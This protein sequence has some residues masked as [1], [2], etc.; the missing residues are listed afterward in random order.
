ML[1]HY[2]HAKNQSKSPCQDCGIFHH[3]WRRCLYFYGDDRKGLLTLADGDANRWVQAGTVTTIWVQKQH[4]TENGMAINTKSL[5]LAISAWAIALI[6]PLAIKPARA[7]STIAITEIRWW[8]EFPADQWQSIRFTVPDQDTTQAAGGGQRRY[9]IQI[10]TLFALTDFLC[11]H[12]PPAQWQHRA[13][14]S[15]ITWSY[16]AANGNVAMGNFKVSCRLA[17]HVAI[18][19]GLKNAEPFEI[20]RTF[21]EQDGRPGITTEHYAVS[22]LN[23][24]GAK[25]PKWLAFTQTFR[26]TNVHTLPSVPFPV[27]AILPAVKARTQ[28]P[29]LLPSRSLFNDVKPAN[30]AIDASANGYTIDIY[31]TPTCRAGACYFG[32]L[33]AERH[34]KLFSPVDSLPRDTFRQIELVNGVKGIFFNGCGAYCTA[35]VEWQYQG[36]LY[37]VTGKNGRQQALVETANSA[38]AAGVR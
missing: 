15:G 22:P 16:E 29:I 6:A 14:D 8:N 20:Q 26:P 32:S 30:L 3:R 33:S 1:C 23:V 10:A 7:E 17:H 11:Q 37:R 21:L 2:N 38:I 9:D 35:F 28:V 31:A 27:Q 19:Y 36:I 24:T 34:G 13:A 25:I 18:A 4:G 5:I 12:A